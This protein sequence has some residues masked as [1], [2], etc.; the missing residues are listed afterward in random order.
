MITGSRS[1]AIVNGPSFE[2]I[3][4]SLESTCHHLYEG[5]I[6]KLVNVEFTVNSPIRL[7]NV[8]GD[9]AE[10]E[11]TCRVV[12]AIVG[13]TLNAGVEPGVCELQAMVMVPGQKLRNG[14]VDN[15]GRS[16][17]MRYN[18]ISRRGNITLPGT[19]DVDG[20]KG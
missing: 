6:R 10:D 18:I 17:A 3:A 9:G 5:N 15:G 11:C 8:Q 1:F 20:R 4:K 7:H 13:F 19:I 14:L 2:M 12:A 16:V